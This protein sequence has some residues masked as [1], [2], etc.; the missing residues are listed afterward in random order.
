MYKFDHQKFAD[1]VIACV[2]RIGWN[3]FI[4]KAKTT[5]K[6]MLRAMKWRNGTI[7]AQ[8]VAKF[9]NVMG[10]SPLVYFKPVLR[11][12]RGE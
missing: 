9:C 4:F 12:D 7:S 2:E 8:T 1:D 6:V 5:E 3:E 11:G 10:R